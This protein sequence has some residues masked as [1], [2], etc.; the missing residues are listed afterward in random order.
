MKNH[1]P[2]LVAGLLLAVSTAQTSGAASGQLDPTFFCKTSA[3]QCKGGFSLDFRLSTVSSISVKSGGRILTASRDEKRKL[4]IGAVRPDGRIQKKF[5]TKGLSLLD[6]PARPAPKNKQVYPT[7]MVETSNG[8]TIVAGTICRSSQ[9]DDQCLPFVARVSKKGQL[10]STFGRNSSGVSILQKVKHGTVTGITI[11]SNGRILL[12]ID[13]LSKSMTEGAYGILACLSPNGRLD[14]SFGPNGDGYFIGQPVSFPGVAPEY[15]GSRFGGVVSIPGGGVAVRLALSGPF[16]TPNSRIGMFKLTSQ[17]LLDTSFAN[18]AG[19]WLR[20]PHSE[21]RGAYDFNRWMITPGIVRTAA[22]TIIVASTAL[23]FVGEM[24]SQVPIIRFFENGD[25]F[26]EYQEFPL[27]GYFRARRLAIDG[28]GRPYLIGDLLTHLGNL[29]IGVVR[30]LPETL[31]KDTTFGG[32]GWTVLFDNIGYL[33]TDGTV[34]FQPDG[35]LLLACAI[36]AEVQEPNA[37]LRFLVD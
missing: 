1:V 30:L 26:V 21:T 2:H 29:G 5:A 15:V 27:D 37:L 31:S 12:T 13:R 8:A 23:N 25:S 20:W 32:A 16:P 9:S 18:G 6:L 24:T 4:L 34:A 36:L 10:D 28:T 11:D 19:W 35:K 3:G 33:G 7:A 17:G 22:G 14:T